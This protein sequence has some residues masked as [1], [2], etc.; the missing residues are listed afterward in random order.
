MI[1][2]LMWIKMITELQAK[3]N[4]VESLQKALYEETCAVFSDLD[5][6]KGKEFELDYISR[7]GGSWGLQEV[8]WKLSFKLGFA[9]PVMTGKSWQVGMSSVKQQFTKHEVYFETTCP[10]T[11]VQFIH[12]YQIKI[13][14]T[15]KIDALKA[16]LEMVQ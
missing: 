15:K 13:K 12:T 9:L 1:A 14:K 4:S 5:W 7:P 6:V 2:L 10:M 16:L 3:V 11:L 8:C